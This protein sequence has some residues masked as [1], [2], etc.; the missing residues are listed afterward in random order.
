[1]DFVLLGVNSQKIA[2]R[3]IQLEE[4]AFGRK[5]SYFSKIEI[6]SMPVDLNPLN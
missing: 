2:I 4:S 6:V 3:P 1:M 5:G